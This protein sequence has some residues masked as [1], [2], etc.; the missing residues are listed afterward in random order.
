MNAPSISEDDGVQRPNPVREAPRQLWRDL[1][2]KRVVPTELPAAQHGVPFQ[3]LEVSLHGV[4]IARA[5]GDVMRD[6][7]SDTRTNAELLSALDDL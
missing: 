7:V 3:L 1:A 5:E 4:D 2:P 6:V